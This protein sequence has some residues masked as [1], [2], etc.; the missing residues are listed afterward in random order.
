MPADDKD[1]G[2]WN[3]HPDLPLKDPS[4]FAKGTTRAISLAGSAAI[5]WP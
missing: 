1:Y 5:G 4:I 3:Y 2:V